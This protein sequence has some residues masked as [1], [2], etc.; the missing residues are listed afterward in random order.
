MFT[1][2]SMPPDDAYCWPPVSK[3]FI[4]LGLDFYQVVHSDTEYQTIGNFKQP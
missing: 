1:S 4:K 2:Q 3:W